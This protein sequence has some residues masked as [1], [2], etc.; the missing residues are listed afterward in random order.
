VATS[1]ESSS[2][3]PDLEPCSGSEIG[4]D[5]GATERR[6]QPPAANPSR[7]P[8]LT[9]HDHVGLGAVRPPEAFALASSRDREADREACGGGH[10]DRVAIPARLEQADYALGLQAPRR[11]QASRGRG[12]ERYWAIALLANSVDVELVIRQGRA[13]R[14]Q[15][16]RRYL[17]AQL[18]QP[19]VTGTTA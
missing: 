16:D 19:L 11:A 9:S 14:S 17:R 12:R 3:S 13:L 15:H 6:P 8:A 4:V 7:Q 18:Q 2:W 5:A 1:A 10:V